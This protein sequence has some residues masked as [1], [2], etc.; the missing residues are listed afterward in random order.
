MILR[1]SNRFIK[2][3]S[4]TIVAATFLIMTVGRCSELY[5]PR[6][7]EFDCMIANRSAVLNLVIYL[8]VQHYTIADYWQ[9]ILHPIQSFVST[10][11]CQV[12]QQD[13]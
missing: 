3:N 10:A 8:T 11:E 1:Y 9:I 5:L 13:G 7:A 2:A 4:L 6:P 12:A